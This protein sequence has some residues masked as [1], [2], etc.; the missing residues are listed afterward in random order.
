MGPI[1]PN[2]IGQSA[3]YEAFEEAGGYGVRV[4]IGAGDCQAGCIQQHVWTYHVDPDGTV[5]LVSDE[6]DDISLPPATGTGDQF[7]LNVALTAGPTCP[8]MRN[9]PD[10]NCADRP[11]VNT[12][13]DVYDISGNLV[14]SG[15]SGADGLAT[16]QLPQGAYYVVVPPVPGLMGQAEPLAF[17]G[18]GGDTVSLTF[19]YDTGIR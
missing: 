14:V 10:P 9:P 8:V 7:T 6:G 19:T 12:E 16:A 2:V 13:I 5:T 18:V 11:V 15:L 17:A 3:W 4:T 1:L